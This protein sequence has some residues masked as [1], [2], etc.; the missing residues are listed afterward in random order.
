MRT[1]HVIA[2]FAMPLMVTHA[3]RAVRG[4]AW[5][6]TGIQTLRIHSPSRP[7]VLHGGEWGSGGGGG[8]EATSE[9]STGIRGGHILAQLHP[10]R[11]FFLATSN[12]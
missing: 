4:L 8:V 11:A 1:Q 3:V 9:P 7:Q 12:P 6:P 10:T 2:R 5:T